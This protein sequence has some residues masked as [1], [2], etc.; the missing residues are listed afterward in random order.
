MKNSHMARPETEILVHIAAPARAADDVRYRALARAYLDFEPANVTEVQPGQWSEVE[1]ETQ[2]SRIEFVGYGIHQPP[3]SSQLSRGIESPILSFENA[4]HN[5]DSPGLRPV[6][7]LEHYISETQSS[8]QAPPSEIPD[9]MPNNNAPFENIC[10]PSRA[11]DFFTSSLESQQVD[12][13]P[14]AR[15]RSQRLA[16]GSDSGNNLYSQPR[17]SPRRSNFHQAARAG[18][19]SLPQQSS[20]PE[21]SLPRLRVPSVPPQSS[22]DMGPPRNQINRQ[23]RSLPHS[24][25]NRELQLSPSDP[26]NKVIPQSPDVCV[27]QRPL[28]QPSQLSTSDIIEETIL[29]SS[30]PSQISVPCTQEPPTLAR[31]DSE[32][33]TKRR[34]TAADPD[35]GQPLTRSASDIGPRRQ[36]PVQLTS[37]KPTA[38]YKSKLQ[39]YSPSPPAAQTDLRPEDVISPVLA[40]LATEL[41]L[42][43]RFRPQSQT[44]ELRPFERGYWLV[45]TASWP[46]D[47]KLSAWVFLS[48]YIEKGIA[49][50]G[51]SC[52]RDR[53][54]SWLKLRCWGCV[55]GHM[56][57][58][59]YVASRRQVKDTGMKW[60]GGDGKAVVVMAPR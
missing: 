5:F 39:V 45:E 16:T 44:R 29:Y 34:R 19:K 54:F 60:Y 48:D 40:K 14:L 55:V 53:D 50:W 22:S 12:S 20:V 33:V 25:L 30:N 27:Q 18:E 4:E 32:P 1:G 3:P 31:A 47:L 15:R 57:L 51:T 10:T 9:S 17:R 21:P 24:S 35:P 58:L 11:L 13:S 42:S 26:A 43:V 6:P 28:P 41:D 52:S 37:I 38:Y 49:G 46:A 23:L 7:V 2:L 8:W 59:L 36:P 56:H